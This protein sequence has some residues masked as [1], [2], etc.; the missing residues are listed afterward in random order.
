MNCVGW[1]TLYACGTAMAICHAVMMKK[2]HDNAPTPGLLS[3]RTLTNDKPSCEDGSLESAPS[4]PSSL[5]VFCFAAF[6]PHEEQRLIAHIKHGSFSPVNGC[7]HFEIHSNT[8][9]PQNLQGLIPDWLHWK[10]SVNGNMTAKYA[11]PPYRWKKTKAM[12]THIFLQIY[13][14]IFRENVYRNH[15]W[16]VKLDLDTAASFHRVKQVLSMHPKHETILLANNGA[17]CDEMIGPI[18][19]FSRWAAEAYA[20]NVTACETQVDYR[21]WGEDHYLGEC[22]DLLGVK[23][24]PEPGLLLDVQKDHD[25][26]SRKVMKDQIS[27]G[28]VRRHAA[29]HPIK[30]HTAL[31]V[32]LNLL[33]RCEFDAMPHGSPCSNAP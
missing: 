4:L 2:Y 17:A 16:I 22:L 31:E 7:T 1:F 30:N 27:C 5:R 32:M 3:G 29:Y 11:R 14:A 10:R 8:S 19:A 13:R 18:M 25:I 26:W 15:D 24:H 28:D 12:N 6:S 33:A 9:L 23:A 20:N 21:K